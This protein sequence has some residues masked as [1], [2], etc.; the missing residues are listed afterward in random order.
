MAS[1]G[2]CCRRRGL[3]W[4]GSGEGGAG[5]CGPYSGRCALSQGRGLR[6]ERPARWGSGGSAGEGGGE[7]RAQV[8]GAELPGLPR[9]FVPK[10]GSRRARNPE[11]SALGRAGPLRVA[12]MPRAVPRGQRG[13]RAAR[14][15]SQPAGVTRE[16]LM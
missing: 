13:R 8:A 11:R 1:A 3:E 6:G 2:S 7:P 10:S 16:K 15:A 12:G 4:G 14:S 5:G 9:G